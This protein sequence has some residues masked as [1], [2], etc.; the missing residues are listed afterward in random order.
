M[1]RWPRSARYTVRPMMVA[2]PEILPPGVEA[3]LDLPGA[4]VDGVEDAVVGA[5]VDRRAEAG[6]VRDGGGGV[7][8]GARLDGPVEL[9]GVGVVGVHATVGVAEEH[10]PVEDRGGGVEGPAAQQGPFGAAAPQQAAVGLG[11]RLDLAAVVAE[12]QD[13]AREAGARLHRAGRVVGPDDAAGAVVEGVHG[14]VL[15]AEEEASVVEQRRGL[16]GARKP[17]RP[18]D[19]AGLGAHRHHPP[20]SAGAAAVQERDVDGVRGDRG[21]RCRTAR[22]AGG[23]T[24][25]G[26]CG[27]RR[28]SVRRCRPAGRCGRRR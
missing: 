13:P 12:V 7:H 6:G 24:A 9:P 2:E 10:A 3:P 14:P 11:D 15:G 21:T 19:G 27:C 22:R 5:E 23:S 16:G 20:G 18:A 4:G 8:V 25:C 26:R 1:R 17:A 28:R